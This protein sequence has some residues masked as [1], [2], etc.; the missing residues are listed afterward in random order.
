MHHSRGGLSA[1]VQ[2]RAH[3]AGAV[4]QRLSSIAAGNSLY[5]LGLLLLAPCWFCW[6]GA[7]SGS[8]SQGVFSC[9]LQ[10]GCT[11]PRHRL[12]ESWHH[13]PKLQE[14]KFSAAVNWGSVSDTSTNCNSLHQTGTSTVSR[15]HKT[16]SKFSLILERKKLLVRDKLVICFLICNDYA[17]KEDK[18]VTSSSKIIYRLL[19]GKFIM[20]QVSLNLAALQV[21][22]FTPSRILMA[23]QTGCTG[24]VLSLPDAGLHWIFRCSSL[25][26]TKTHGI[27]GSYLSWRCCP[28]STKSW[29]SSERQLTPSS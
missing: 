26:G 20:P 9:A 12:V 29:F 18:A 6:M 10:L 1:P 11:I 27:E 14:I 16:F 24:P 23:L 21:Y 2:C 3:S 19:T 5:L 15:S 13:C 22:L 4:T 25:Q 28:P 7:P 17:G 8:L